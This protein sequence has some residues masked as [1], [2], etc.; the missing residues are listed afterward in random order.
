MVDDS[1][2]KVG[3]LFE[4]G[5]PPAV[6]LRPLLSVCRNLRAAAILR[7]CKTCNITLGRV[8]KGGPEIYSCWTTHLPGVDFPT[9]LY[10]HELFIRADFSDVCSGL[11]LEELAWLPFAILVFPKVCFLAVSLPVIPTAP[12]PPHLMPNPLFAA[13]NIE[14][15]VQS[16]KRLVPAIKMLR[17][18]IS[19]SFVPD[20][21]I[22]EY[23]LGT[24]VRQLSQLASDVEYITYRKPMRP[25]LQPTGISRI[26]YM[27]ISGTNS[28]ELVMQ[29]AR[30]NATSLVSLLLNFNALDS[31]GTLIQ[32]ADGSYVQYP[33]LARLNDDTP[34]R[35]NAATLEYLDMDLSPL[36]VSAIKRHNVFLPSSHPKLRC[37][38]L[39]QRL[40]R[41]QNTF[42]TNAE[43]LRFVLSI[44][45][46]ASVRVMQNMLQSPFLPT[47]VPVL[48]DH[49]SIQMLELLYTPLD[50]WKVIGLVSALPLLSDLQSTAPTVGLPPPGI[51]V[52]ELPCYVRETY[53]PV[54]AQFRRWRFDAD[55]DADFKTAAKCVLLLAMACPSFDYATVPD[56]C[57]ELFMAN[58]KELIALD[59]FKQRAPRLQR[60]LFGGWKSEIPSV[61]VA[62]VRIVNAPST[63]NF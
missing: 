59:G 55:S 47:M 41:V 61:A 27:D 14:A 56:N 37:V 15:Y 31:I 32:H 23:L 4:K 28:S 51:Y 9:H 25:E 35:G 52:D 16:I 18:T 17:I 40:T 22:T 54:G 50:L 1:C 53:A 20:S 8:S 33:H 57:H 36:A 48:S 5:K 11:A 58:M 13:A 60:L 19:P 62:Q 43:Y 3:T 44:G 38:K 49:S 39:G 34:F 2:F 42:R 29:L 46:N 12:L 24:Y 63:F 45:P 26:A 7:L 6:L 21:Q 10:A 30:H